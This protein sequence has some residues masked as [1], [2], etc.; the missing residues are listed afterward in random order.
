MEKNNF[1][2]IMR[3][4]SR[5]KERIKIGEKVEHH[6]NANEAEAPTDKVEQKTP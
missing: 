2:N 3:C 1:W 6:E 4:F 5:L